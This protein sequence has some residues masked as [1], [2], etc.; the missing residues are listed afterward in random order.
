MS[1]SD[2]TN[3]T[4]QVVFTSNSE[5][6]SSTTCSTSYLITLVNGGL[7]SPLSS[8]TMGADGFY[9]SASGAALD[10]FVLQVSD[11]W[12]SDRFI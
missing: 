4:F 8:I 1:F 3:C 2:F 9:P 12:L 11:Q 5:T 7:G 6:I 10:V